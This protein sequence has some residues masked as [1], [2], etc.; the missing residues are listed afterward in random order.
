MAKEKTTEEVD[1]NVVSE[2]E[3]Q[4]EKKPKRQLDP[5]RILT[6]TVLGICLLLL[7]LHVLSD[8]HVPYTD[9]ARLT[10]LAI[11]VAPRVQ[12]NLTQINVGLHSRVTVGDTLFQIDPR[13]F[14]LAIKSAEARLDNTAQQ[15]GARTA[16]VKS[17]AGRL[18]VARAQLDRAQRNYDRVEAVLKENPGALSLA[19]KDVAETSLA[20][21]VET[22]SSAEADLEKAQQQLGVSGPDNPQL[23]ASV[24]AVEQAYLNRAFSTIYAP[25]NGVIESY[26]VDLG[27]FCQPGQPMAMLLTTTDLWIQ[28]DMKENNLYHMDPGDPVEFVLD[29]A[30]GQVFEGTIRSIGHGV[31]SG[32]YNRGELP[33]VKNSQSW[34]RDPQRFPVIISFNDRELL[35]YTRLGGQVDVVVFNGDNGFLNTVGRWRLRLNGWLSYLR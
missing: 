8:R 32:Y 25:A 19:D 16:T 10:G 6:W 13:P 31:A 3:Q 2:A 29:V 4:E 22:V 11:P 20:Q 27:F 14:D 12:G 26:N 9:Q 30:P 1:E 28:A 23:R 33:T 34:L 17:A 7:T 15:V 21:A 24:V 18:G 5:A 35:E